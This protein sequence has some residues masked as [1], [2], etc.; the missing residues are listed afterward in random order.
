MKTDQCPLFLFNDGD[1]ETKEKLRAEEAI[2]ESL[3]QA[4]LA[5]WKV[6]EK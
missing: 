5:H 6:R 1:S 3:G 4:A 2:A